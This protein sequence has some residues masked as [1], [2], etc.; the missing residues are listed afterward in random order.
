MP[1]DTP[2][3]NKVEV[4]QYGAHLVLVRGLIDDCGRMVPRASR[5]ARLV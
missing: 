1:E 5:K 4:L 3:T 2:A